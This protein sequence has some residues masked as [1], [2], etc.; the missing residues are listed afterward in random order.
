MMGEEGVNQ[1]WNPH[2]FPFSPQLEDFGI[3][4]VTF[5]LNKKEKVDGNIKFFFTFI[6]FINI[7]GW[8]SNS[9]NTHLRDIVV[10][11]F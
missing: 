6:L 2:S 5:F 10:T 8:E 1:T 9:Q 11:N 3:L 4:Q 7:S